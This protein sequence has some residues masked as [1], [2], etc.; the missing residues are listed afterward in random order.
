VATVFRSNF[1]GL[2]IVLPQAQ[3]KP[4]KGLRYGSVRDYDNAQ[5]N[6][7]SVVSSLLKELAVTLSITASR[8]VHRWLRAPAAHRD[9]PCR[10]HK[11]EGAL[12]RPFRL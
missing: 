10:A 5:R 11:K 12:T 7:Q 2:A 6:G 3:V 4:T 1:E 8:R 9:W